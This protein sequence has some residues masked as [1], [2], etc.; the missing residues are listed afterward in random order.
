MEEEKKGCFSVAGNILGGII[1]LG[2][3]LVVGLVMIFAGYQQLTQ[4]LKWDEYKQAQGEITYLQVLRVEENKSSNTRST[5]AIYWKVFGDYAYT[6]DGKKYSELQRTAL[7]S[8]RDEGDARHAMKSHRV[9]EPITLWYHPDR[10]GEPILVN[11]IP[12]MGG[13]VTFLLFGGVLAIFAFN[14]IFSLVMDYI[15]KEDDS[16]TDK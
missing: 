14:M 9:G 8:K 10:P 3:G 11:D 1:F 7:E 6:V 5:S 16:V 13:A 15:G 4:H 12:T 2:G